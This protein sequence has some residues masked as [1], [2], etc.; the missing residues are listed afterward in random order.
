MAPNDID[1]QRSFWG[2]LFRR[3]RNVLEISEPHYGDVDSDR[4]LRIAPGVT[5]HGYVRAPEVWV[6]GLLQGYVLTPRLCVNAGGQL[7]GDVVAVQVDTEPEGKI[8]GR[9]TM[10]SADQFQSLN[11]E[12]SEG[13]GLMNQVELR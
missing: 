9:L 6:A 12:M 7:R 8:R 11:R 10:L 4:P 1:K 3:S 2:N 13:S 5:L